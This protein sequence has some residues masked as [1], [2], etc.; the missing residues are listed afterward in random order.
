MID[1][2]GQLYFFVKATIGLGINK[3]VDL[4]INKVIS[5]GTDV[6]IGFF[7]FSLW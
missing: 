3:A 6:V 7:R 1:F 5:I 2:A 4:A